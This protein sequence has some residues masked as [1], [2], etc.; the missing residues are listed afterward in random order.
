[1]THDADVHARA[2]RSFGRHPSGT[3]PRAE[4]IPISCGSDYCA[5]GGKRPAA[6]LLVVHHALLTTGRYR[7]VWHE[8]VCAPNLKGFCTLSFASSVREAGPMG[9][10]DGVFDA[11]RSES[12]SDT[13]PC[14][15]LHAAT[16]LDAALGYYS[17]L[18]Q[19]ISGVR[20]P[21]PGEDDYD[22]VRPACTSHTRSRRSRLHTARLRHKHAEGRTEG[23][24]LPDHR[25]NRRGHKLCDS[26]MR[27]S[28]LR[29]LS[30]RGWLVA[31]YHS[32]VQRAQPIA[33]ASSDAR[34]ARALKATADGLACRR[35]HLQPC[36]P[37]PYTSSETVDMGNAG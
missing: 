4:L 6:L 3:H 23:H 22:Q 33:R 31:L 30:A 14:S 37:W 15:S 21:Q 19:P 25:G 36:I 29:L 26:L 8:L 28:S 11:Q 16:F 20:T 35:L 34:A 10:D 12:R 1:M 18:E 27:K 5:V 17:V 9:G 2:Y 24:C 13:P 32:D 7:A